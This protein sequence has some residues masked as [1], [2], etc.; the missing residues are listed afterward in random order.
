ML[1][2]DV[3]SGWQTLGA[4]ER[5][6]LPETSSL[7]AALFFQSNLQAGCLGWIGAMLEGG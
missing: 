7:F 2:I 5:E 4:A 1:I 6:S 3:D